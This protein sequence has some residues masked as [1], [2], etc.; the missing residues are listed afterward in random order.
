[1]MGPNPS[2]DEKTTYV[3]FVCLF[4]GPMLTRHLPGARTKIKLVHVVPE[5]N[6]IY[7]GKNIVSLSVVSIRFLM[8]YL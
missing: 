7:M 4:K 2:D 3:C 1:M 8:E 6:V 5:N